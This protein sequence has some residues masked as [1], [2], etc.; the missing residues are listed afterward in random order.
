VGTPLGPR[1][2]SPRPAHEEARVS[3]PGISA[4]WQASDEQRCVCVC[5][6]CVYTHTH[7]GG[8]SPSWEEILTSQ[9]CEWLSSSLLQACTD[10]QRLEIVF[11]RLIIS[12]ASE[13]IETQ[14]VVPARASSEESIVIISSSVSSTRNAAP[15]VI[16]FLLRISTS[17][18]AIAKGPFSPSSCFDALENRK[19][20]RARTFVRSFLALPD[21][22][23]RSA[24][25]PE[26]K[27]SDSLGGT[28]CFDGFWGSRCLFGEP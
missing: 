25:K 1:P 9:S 24:Q 12:H 3:G 11:I 5:V 18:R 20:K 14:T 19:E 2:G 4:E 27:W 13:L 10:A 21:R 28:S 6:F 15:V 22:A 17:N 23:R 7:M 26:R 16:E 8:Y